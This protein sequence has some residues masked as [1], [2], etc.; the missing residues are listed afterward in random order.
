MLED[1]EEELLEQEEEETSPFELL[2]EPYLFKFKNKQEEK[3]IQELKDFKL[4]RFEYSKVISKRIEQ[5]SKGYKPMIDVRSIPEKNRTLS[6]I[7]KKELE[8]GLMPFKVIRE[9]P[10]KNKIQVLNLFGKKITEED[11]I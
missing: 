7:A 10:S 3:I 1:E 11:V 5:L 6:L 8:Q 4:T 2:L 9:F